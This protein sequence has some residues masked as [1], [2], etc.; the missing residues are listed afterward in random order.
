MYNKSRFLFHTGQCNATDVIC[1]EMK[2]RHRKRN[3]IK[4]NSTALLLKIQ[5]FN[6]SFSRY[7]S[8]IMNFYGFFLDNFFFIYFVVS[9]LPPLNDLWP[10]SS[11]ITSANHL[12][13]SKCFEKIKKFLV[14]SLKTLKWILIVCTLHHTFFY[15]HK[16]RCS[17]G[18]QTVLIIWLIRLWV[19]WFCV[20]W[21]ITVYVNFVSKRNS[22]EHNL[23]HDSLKYGIHR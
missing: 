20:V 11:G 3:W 1:W 13:L 9:W 17:Q 15:L 21:L 14:K 7:I 22:T 4:E 18:K 19:I 2:K 23:F 6:C 10:N 8:I 12:P 5:Y 16:L